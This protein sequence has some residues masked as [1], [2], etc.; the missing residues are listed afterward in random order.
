MQQVVGYVLMGSFV[1]YSIV[2]CWVYLFLSTQK[3]FPVCEQGKKIDTILRIIIFKAVICLIFLS[4]L[5]EPYFTSS[6]S[7]FPL[8]AHLHVP[9]L[10]LYPVLPLKFCYS[11]ADIS[12][13][14]HLGT[15]FSL[16]RVMNFQVSFSLSGGNFVCAA[17]K[18]CTP[19]LLVFPIS[20]SCSLPRN[21]LEDCGSSLVIFFF[22]SRFFFKWTLVSSRYGLTNT[23]SRRS[24]ILWK[25]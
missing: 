2:T 11:E 1:L 24:D 21:K 14:A 7:F 16:A 15:P 13:L 4:F 8:T 9:L 19:T 3:I 25:L 5:Q 23:R 17:S 20:S 22:L 18:S 10:T 6:V 12:Y